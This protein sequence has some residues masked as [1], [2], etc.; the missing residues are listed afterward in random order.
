[1]SARAL[2]GVVALAMAV[3]VL[4]IAG[5]AVLLGGAVTAGCQ[6]L[7]A[8]SAGVPSSAGDW[9]TEQVA[10]AT[11]IIT[12]GRQK[13]VPQRGWIIA[14]ATAMQE[15]GLRNLPGGDR[16]SIGLFQQRPSQGWGT[17]EQLADPAYAAGTFYDKLLSIGG[18]QTMPLTE[19]AQR[20]QV[21]AHPSAYA[22]WEDDATTLVNNLAGGQ[23]R[24]ALVGRGGWVTPV[25]GPIVSGFRTPERPGHDGIVA[26]LAV[27]DWDGVQFRLG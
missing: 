7:A 13:G 27:S 11:T 15:S 10:N 9:N 6:P 21:S 4:C 17:P 18:W 26:A 24:C 8:T 12:T 16:D 23:A 5:P 2:G 20:V 1:M 25:S 14:V 19:A 22:A 3:A